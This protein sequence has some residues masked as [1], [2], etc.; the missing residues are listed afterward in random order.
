[1]AN[2][3][4][5][6]LG[7]AHEAAVSQGMLGQVMAAAGDVAGGRLLLQASLARLEALNSEAAD[8][9]REVLAELDPAT[10]SPRS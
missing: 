2:E 7:L 1:M 9:L 6:I 10:P 8:T 5:E 3:I 4:Q